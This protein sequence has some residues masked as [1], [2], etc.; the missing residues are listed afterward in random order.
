MK[1]KLIKW[2]ISL[3][4]SIILILLFFENKSYKVDLPI[5]FSFYPKEM[6]WYFNEPVQRD[7]DYFIS[8]HI[9]GSEDFNGEEFC[10]ENKV[11]KYMPEKDKKF[12]FDIK[13]YD[14]FKISLIKIGA[15]FEKN[16][17]KNMICYYYTNDKVNNESVALF[18]FKNGFYRILQPSLMH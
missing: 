12:N 11:D 1:K 9:Y 17:V 16:N 8:N 13:N 6:K 10:E 4:I 3:V 14:N 2:I 7:F 18:V 15:S 5:Q